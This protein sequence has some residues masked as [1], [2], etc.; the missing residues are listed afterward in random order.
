MYS[1]GRVHRRPLYISS[2][3]GFRVE[4]GSVIVPFYKNLSAFLDLY[5]NSSGWPYVMVL[6]C[7]SVLMLMSYQ[8]LFSTLVTRVSRPGPLR[9]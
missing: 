5:C 9:R 1:P 2:L 8:E 4:S 7:V 3:A 6:A